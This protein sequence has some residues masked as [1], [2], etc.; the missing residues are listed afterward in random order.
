MAAHA[1]KVLNIVCACFH[2]R[3]K[4]PTGVMEGTCYFVPSAY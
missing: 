3:D 1:D 2:K 4:H